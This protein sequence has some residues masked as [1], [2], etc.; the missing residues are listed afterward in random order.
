M[1]ARFFGLKTPLSPLISRSS[2]FYTTFNRSQSYL[3][4]HQPFAP[5]SKEFLQLQSHVMAKLND[6]NDGSKLSQIKLKK[7]T[8]L[9]GL[10]NNF[11]TI[12]GGIPLYDRDFTVTNNELQSIKSSIKELGAKWALYSLNED[13]ECVVR[14]TACGQKRYFVCHDFLDIED[15]MNLNLE[16]VD[17]PITTRKLAL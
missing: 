13:I 11:N 14:K 1:F 7:G 8:Q 9:V 6:Q 17:N 3:L 5:H 15:E 12:Y 2:M 4:S 16:A 10:T